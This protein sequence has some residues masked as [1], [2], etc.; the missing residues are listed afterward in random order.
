MLI[1]SFHAAQAKLCPLK[2]SEFLLGK[3]CH[4]TKVLHLVLLRNKVS[5][6][7]FSELRKEG[8]R[9]AM[10]RAVK[11]S[12]IWG[13][14]HV[15]CIFIT[16]PAAAELPLHKSFH[17][18]FFFSMEG[19]ISSTSVLSFHIMLLLEMSSFHTVPLSHASMGMLT[20]ISSWH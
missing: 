3:N 4:L 16:F 9:W 10:K 17:L 7:V 2:L 13:T 20:I 14:M 12:Y 5:F 19:K 8:Q 6:C 15:M 1:A 18:S 11:H